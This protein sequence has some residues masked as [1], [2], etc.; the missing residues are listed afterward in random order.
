MSGAPGDA[1]H[2]WIRRVLDFDPAASSSTTDGRGAKVRLAQARLAWSNA[3]TAAAVE[4]KQVEKTMLQAVY[5]MRIADEVAA[6]VWRL[7]AMFDVL[8]TRLIDKLDEALNAAD[9]IDRKR[10][11]AQAQ[12][13]T[14][15]YLA[16]LGKDPLLAE[17]DDN[18]F[19][20]VSVSA[21]LR[22]TLTTLRK[23]LS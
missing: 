21:S 7:Y 9:D 6:N 12:A 19:A 1:K 16:F 14:D 15:E 2:D 5:G 11:Q 4:L 10:M 23:E 20:K 8:D 18:P 3:R 22:T 13:I 17:I